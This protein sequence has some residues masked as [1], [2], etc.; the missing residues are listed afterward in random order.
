MNNVIEQRREIT[1]KVKDVLISSL[2]LDLTKD[3]ISNDAILFGSGLGLD[4][5]DALQL[6]V[7]I[8]NEFQITLPQSQV[9]ILRSINTIVDFILKEQVKLELQTPQ[10]KYIEG[11][12]FQN[13][14]YECIRTSAGLTIRDDIIVYKISGDLAAQSLNKIITSEVENLAEN[15]S[16]Q[17][18][19][20]DEIGKV[21]LY[22]EIACL[23]EYYFLLTNKKNQLIIEK[24]FL[25]MNGIEIS[26]LDHAVIALDGPEVVN[27][28]EKYF[29]QEI[30]GM[31][32]NMVLGVN[33]NDRP[34]QLIRTNTTGE[35]GYL[36]ILPKSDDR[37]FIQELNDSAENPI[38]QC[39]LAVH[40][41]LRLEAFSFDENTFIPNKENPFEAGLQWMIDLKKYEFIGKT[42]I[43]NLLKSGIKKKLIPFISSS[44]LKNIKVN[45]PVQFDDKKVGYVST[46]EYSPAL[47]QFIG[48]A[49]I[50]SDYA[51]PGLEL[52]LTDRDLKIQL[53][54]APFF[55]TKSHLL[56]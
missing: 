40:K 49:Y 24:I 41:I 21:E 56:T 15:Y 28:V 18:L 33:K 54:S 8:E 19:I 35:F 51:W 4:S 42:E 3:E 20:L 14:D 1:E 2:N 27:I 31:S 53:T 46:I 25:D 36:I 22:V 48:Y 43:E 5:I 23:D 44:N 55:I 30:I 7:G 17:S 16:I 39:S 10:F 52:S 9:T 6:F 50:N 13:S 29:G 38:H 45:D 34:A 47:G 12:A 37:I 32:P 26:L 11:A